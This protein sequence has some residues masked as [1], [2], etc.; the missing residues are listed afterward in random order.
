MAGFT[1]SPFRYLY[2]QTCDVDKGLRIES[3]S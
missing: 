1:A 2:E 3:V